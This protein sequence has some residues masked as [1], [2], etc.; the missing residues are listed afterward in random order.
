MNR[1]IAIIAVVLSL[2]I[3]LANSSSH[4]TGGSSGYTGAPGDSTC[5]QCHSGSNSALD[6]TVTIEGLPSNIITN[7]TY[8][9]T[10][11]VTNPNGNAVKGGFQL[12][13]LTGANLNAG[14]MSN[15]STSTII[16]TVSGGKQYFGH[17]PAINFPGSNELV[18][19]VDW[20]APATTGSN[21]IIKFYASSVIANGNGGTSG[22]RVVFDNVEL[23]ISGGTAALGVTISNEQPTSCANSQDG[24]AIANPTGGTPN[25][26]FSW[27]NGSTSM[28]PN[29]LPPGTSTVTVTDASGSTATAS[30]TITSPDE[31]IVASTG[32]TICFGGTNGS[33]TSFTTGGVGFYNYQWSNGSTSENQSGLSPGT[34]T[35][36]VT[37][38]NNCTA[39]STTAV[40]TSPV[41]TINGTAVNLSCSDSQDGSISVSQT[42]GTSPFTYAWSNGLTGSTIFNLTAGAYTVTVTDVALCTAL[43]TFQI[44]APLPLTNQ[45]TTTDVSC[46]GE[47]NG[48]VAVNTSGGNSPYE[49]QWSNGATSSGTSSTI[50]NL[51]AGD[52]TV[53]VT[54]FFDCQIESTV[55][56]TEPSSLNIVVTNTQNVSCFEGMD[57]S[58]SLAVTGNTGSVSYL[59]SNGGSTNTISNL[60]AGT[61]TVTITDNGTNCTQT[62][63]YDITEPT[64]ITATISATNVT[65]HG[66]SDGEMSVI[67]SGGTGNY[68]YVWNNDETTATISNLFAGTYTV[69]VMNGPL[70]VYT[71]SGIV[72]Q[73]SPIIVEVISSTPVSCLGAENGSITLISSN[74]TAPYDYVWSNGATTEQLSNVGAGIYMVT[75][76]DANDCSSMGQF[77]VGTT[78][79]FNISLDSVMNI[80]CFGDSTGYASVASNPSYTYLWSNGDTTNYSENLLAG[81]Y[82][83]V[84]IDDA[85]CESNPVNINI[86]QASLIMATST[87]IDTLLCPGETY[88]NI[89]LELS[90]GTGPLTYQWSTS[91]T[92]LTLDS[93]VAGI[94]TIDISDDTGCTESYMYEVIQIAPIQVDSTLWQD[95]ACYG[96]SNGEI[97][98]FAS[99][100]YNSLQYAW[101]NGQSGD[102]VSNLEVGLYILT[103][104]DQNNC[105]VIDSF[106]VTQPDSLSVIVQIMDETTFGLNDGSI[107]LTATGG[108]QPLSII[109]DNGAT[110]FTIDSLSPGIYYYTVFDSNECSING[111]AVVGG[112]SCSLSATYETVN[113]SC[114]NTPDGAII[115]Y[116]DGNV[117]ATSV[118]IYTQNTLV[119]STLDAL[120]ASTYTIIIQDSL[121]CTS[122]LTDITIAS[123][124]PA[125]VL[126]S[127]DIVNPT[128]VTKND[129]SISANISG[130]SGP[131]TYSWSKDFVQI[132]TDVSISNLLPGLYSLEVTDSIGCV[133]KINNIL[134]SFTSSTT[135]EVIGNFTIVPN[136]VTSTMNILSTQD[137]VDEVEI[138]DTHGRSLYKQANVYAEKN[139]QIAESTISTLSNGVYFARIKSGKFI[140]IKKFV[141]INQ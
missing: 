29:D 72:S 102:T 90:G 7:N 4:P 32:S 37:D 28:T 127:L 104:S 64:A 75:V 89:S 25:Y 108:N 122:I 35:I 124:Y 80:A 117:G 105:S 134:L 10:V 125:I 45:I 130:G 56:I 135:D 47:S 16:K 39:S 91:D 40:S 113:S 106:E 23:S 65:C 58:L 116:V 46:F 141:I 73:P 36:T 109:W 3:G 84:A 88:G 62:I 97:L 21:P 93:L 123:T 49:Y 27:S 71:V 11:R 8:T 63:S 69:A 85:G 30:V 87:T 5:G 86:S 2:I 112:G 78:N 133:L 83:V 131:L 53:T 24:S 48:S 26:N 107:S 114:F 140:I 66:G 103:I 14:S 81:I 74:G 43:E 126:D 101:S 82:T 41:M 31:L 136:P 70:C 61:Y 111:W 76:T 60:S 138:Q 132:S 120:W 6:G 12:L 128:G 137:K 38:G 110:S 20:T 44:N 50:N 52:Y 13:A 129:G 55:T 98:V 95:V 68:T 94:Y 100:G 15:T 51:T 115:L 42:G 118:A 19:T 57:G 9:I 119:E 34:Y 59:W 17:S 139:I 18:H 79:S 121:G 22:D 77:T 92:L 99:G 54:D 33:V 1:Y 96:E 67:A